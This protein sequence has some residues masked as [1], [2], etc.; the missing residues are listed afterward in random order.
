MDINTVR[1]IFTVA[2]FTIFIGIVVWAYS[3]SNRSSFEAAGRLPFDGEDDG[4]ER[5]KVGGSNE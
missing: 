3:R 4:V 1:S 2:V 5:K